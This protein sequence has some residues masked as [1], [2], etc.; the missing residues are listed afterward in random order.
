[1]PEYQKPTSLG[2]IWADG[3]DKIKPSDDKIQTGWLPE[4]PTRQNFNWLDNRQ[5]QF[6]AHVNQ[7]GIPVWDIYTPYLASK[8]YTQGSNGI[9]YR[10]K[11]D[12]LAIDPA[13][14][15]T[16]V[17]WEEAFVTADGYFGGKRYVGYESFSSD[18]TAVANHRYFLTSPA[19][20][21]LPAVANQ[22]DAIVVAKRSGIIVQVGTFNLQYGDEA[23]FVFDNGSWVE[24]TSS[25]DNEN[26]VTLSGPVL[27]TQGSTDTYVI[28]NYNSFSQYTV[29]ASVG[30]ATLTNESISL[31]VP[32]PTEQPQITLTVVR[33]GVA[34]MF[35]ITVGAQSIVTPSIVYPTAGQ[36]SVELTPTLQGSDFA[37]APVGQDTH[38]SSQWQVATD[39]GFTDIKFN[40]GTDTVNKT[41]IQVPTGSLNISSVYYARVRY[42][43]AII[44]T[45]AWS[46]AVTF[47]TTNKYVVTPT[48]AVS[49]GPDQVDE[50]PT[51]TTSAFAVFGGSDT[52]AAT[53][54]Q[55]IKVSDSSVVW[56]SL[57]NTTNKTSIT[58]PA[59]ILLEN[60]SYKARA[61]HS[62]AVL[63]SSTWGEYTFITRSQFFTFTPGNIG[64]S[65]GGGYYGGTVKVLG[66]NYAL[67][68]A[69]KAQGGEET[70]LRWNNSITVNPG[71]ASRNDGLAN[72]NAMLND[73]SSV[74]AAA[75]FC[76]G[77]NIN[78]FSDWYLPSRDELELLY[79]SFKP[80]TTPNTTGYFV[81]GINSGDNPSSVPPNTG[82]YQ[83]GVPA[84]TSLDNFKYPTGAESFSTAY[85]WTS[86]Q[87]Q[88][89]NAWTITFR[90]GELTP[91]TISYEGCATR[92][93]RRVLIPT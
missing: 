54:W 37:T 46:S 49:N 30:T 11:K 25:I 45:S 34:S 56:Q 52:H 36:T 89:A 31:V 75:A 2:V 68:L 38:Q 29:S 28:T 47:T 71:A 8:S 18:L 67:I 77:L 85:Y 53:D 72:T 9:I 55:V 10:A 69:P 86:T 26:G 22:G 70:G 61:R 80:T 7:H 35:L 17:Y 84:Q 1:M 13:A 21:T 12:N 93:V 5:D 66:Q 4:I 43:G 63:G 81:G 44:G 6:N 33:D 76:R 27:V 41:T 48:L 73:T 57:G 74:Y 92:A 42:T 90:T 64:Q 40:S 20:V 83:A 32:N 58:I 15:L 16:N 23:T 39:S 19:T 79:R 87:Q 65:Y 3:G 78:G 88:A 14:D 91:I 82:P 51:L 50:T 60:M 24:I 59:N 62:G